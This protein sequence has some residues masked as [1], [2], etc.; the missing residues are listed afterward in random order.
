MRFANGIRPRHSKPSRRATS[1]LKIII[2]FVWDGLLF[3]IPPSIL[4]GNEKDNCGTS[5]LRSVFWIFARAIADP[6]DRCAKCLC[7]KARYRRTSCVLAMPVLQ[8]VGRDTDFNRRSGVQ[9]VGRVLPES[10]PVHGAGRCRISG[11]IRHIALS[12]R[13]SRG[14]FH[15]GQ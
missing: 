1:Q 4:A 14:L 7:F 15:G 11:H 2:G 9:H 6:G 10:H 8:F 13:L 5:G 3:Q 12:V